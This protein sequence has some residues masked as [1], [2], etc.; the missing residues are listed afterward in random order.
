[1]F[2]RHSPSHKISIIGPGKVGTVLGILAAEA[3]FPV[4]AVG[5]REPKKAAECAKRIGATATPCSVEEAAP[6][7][8]LVFLTV[9]DDA[10]ESLCSHLSHKHLFKPGALVVHCSG[11]LSSNILESARREC[12]C[13]IASFHPLLPFSDIEAGLRYIKKACWFIEGEKEATAE[14]TTFSSRIGCKSLPLKVEN[15]ALYHAASVFGYC[16]VTTVIGVAH[17]L[18]NGAGVDPKTFSEA[19]AV[20]IQAMVENIS[21]LGPGAA[22]TGPF[23]RGDSGL[24]KSQMVEIAKI[25]PH[26]GE[27]YK[28]LALEATELALRA[29]R[30][31]QGQGGSLKKVCGSS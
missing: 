12:G 2:N 30:I 21:V 4:V 19:L 18:G 5:G 25:N 23:V 15:K 17:E 10:I 3:G 28:A 7:G 1:M 8:D 24:V 9:S 22:L 20:G 13:Q 27:L 29:G 6:Q 31:S 26:Y 14:L 16:Y 11:A